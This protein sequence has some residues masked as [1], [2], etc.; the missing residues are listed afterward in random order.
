M[1]NRGAPLSNAEAMPEPKKRASTRSLGLPPSK[2]PA[3][4]EPPSKAEKGDPQEG[5]PPEALAVPCF[6]TTCPAILAS[7]YFKPL[8]LAASTASKIEQ[9]GLV[10]N[11]AKVLSMRLAQLVKKAEEIRADIHD[12]PEDEI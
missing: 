10:L 2:K 7:W 1:G 5:D 4:K 9:L 6:P 8:P 11:E 12:G 3:S